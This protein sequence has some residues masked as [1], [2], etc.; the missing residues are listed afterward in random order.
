[1]KYIFLSAIFLLS[2]CTSRKDPLALPQ[3]I[4][5]AV[6]SNFRT[7]EN[8][9]RDIYRHPA[10]TLKFFGLTPNMTVVEIAPAQGWYMEI[11]APLLVKSGQYIMASP[12]ADKPYFIANEEKIHFWMNQYAMVGDKVSA[13]IFSPPSQINL[14]KPSSADMVVTFRNVHN[15]MAAKGE[16]QAFKAFFDVLKTG[17]ILGVV[18]HRA[19]PSQE[20]PLAKS[21]YV[22]EQDVIELA[23]RAGFRLVGSSEINA[24]PKDSKDHPEGVWTL[25]P[26]LKSGD[27]NREKYLAIGESDRMTLKFIKPKNQE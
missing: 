27:K 10:E 16:A 18:E 9:L 21:G 25:P 5:E 12:I 26:T 7:P 3:S 15:W 6:T 24:N 13:V 1:M 20:D 17:G 23:A 8:K 4:D 2:A 11:L 14:G 19:Y 22:R